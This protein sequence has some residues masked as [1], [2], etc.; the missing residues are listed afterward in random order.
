LK[1]EPDRRRRVP[2]VPEKEHFTVTRLGA[3]VAK[4]IVDSVQE[5]GPGLAQGKKD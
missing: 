1:L 5:K 2:I 4:G 3:Y